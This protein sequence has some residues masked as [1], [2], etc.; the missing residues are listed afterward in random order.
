MS[1]LEN[2]FR[3]FHTFVYA[4]NKSNPVSP[5]PVINSQMRDVSF[6]SR[7]RGSPAFVCLT[8]GCLEVEIT[9]VG[10]KSR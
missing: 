1:S 5:A 3:V 7:G 8:G 10:R 9:S 2:V 4:N 6:T